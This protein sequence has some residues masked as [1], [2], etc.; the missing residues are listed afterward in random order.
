MLLPHDRRR[1][2]PYDGGGYLLEVDS[3]CQ[4]NPRPRIELTPM[5]IFT[6]LL[7]VLT[8]L[9]SATPAGTATP[10]GAPATAPPAAAAAPPGERLGEVSFSVSCSASARA[11]FS[12]GVALLHD[13][14]YDEARPQ[15]ERIAKADPACAMAHWGIAMSVFHQ[16][17][18]R[19]DPDTMKLGRRE[20]QA[21]RAR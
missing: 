1:L 14:W 5:K 20:L 13:F 11:P 4:T 16:I 12:R 10:A 6:P 8:A 21:A 17:W 19:P 18:G 9:A 3:D 2:A 15:F 7:L